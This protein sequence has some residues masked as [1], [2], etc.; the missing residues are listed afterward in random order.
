MGG[1]AFGCVFVWASMEAAV[2]SE[3]KISL[4]IMSSFLAATLR[5][6]GFE[7][8]RKHALI[9]FRFLIEPELC[10]RAPRAQILGRAFMATS[11]GHNASHMLA[12]E[13]AECATVQLG[14]T[15]VNRGT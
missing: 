13:T 8:L 9:S 11:R 15:N 3:T 1:C 10:G 2:K 7:P 12:G 4:F 6:C 5:T 14:L